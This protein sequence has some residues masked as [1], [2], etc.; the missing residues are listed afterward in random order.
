[1]NKN[2]ENEQK[3]YG[4]DTIIPLT[5]TYDDYT[6]KPSFFMPVTRVAKI[7][8]CDNKSIYYGLDTLCKTSSL[9]QRQTVEKR[10]KIEEME[11]KIFAYN[12]LDSTIFKRLM[13]LF[14]NCYSENVNIPF[15]FS[16]F[17]SVYK[18]CPDS[19][20]FSGIK[21]KNLCF[22]GEDDVDVYDIWTDFYSDINSNTICDFVKDTEYMKK[23]KPCTDDYK[24]DIPE[25]IPNGFYDKVKTNLTNDP[26]AYYIL[27]VW[28]RRTD[29]D[30]NIFKSN[31]QEYFNL[32][33]ECSKYT[34]ED[35]IFLDK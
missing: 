34:E 35:F 27:P 6:E 2:T 3:T 4:I 25:Y 30:D 14:F 15:S 22:I 28:I 12:G 21:I 8:S 5:S 20:T 13:I 29:K 24:P 7:L 19:E 23:N 10:R 11:N 33:R 26:N 18:K 16:N 17:I 1:M 32:K 31:I 9:I